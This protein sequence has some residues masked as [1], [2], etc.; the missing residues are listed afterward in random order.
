MITTLIIYGI[1][2]ILLCWL[3]RPRRGYRDFIVA[4]KSSGWFMTAFGLFTL[5][6]G[7][8]L[9]AGASFGY[10][11]GWYGAA[12]FIGYGISF[13]LLA[14][15]SQT[16]LRDAS[17][18]MVSYVDYATAKYGRISGFIVFFA[19]VVA[20]FALLVLQLSAGGTVISTFTSMPYLAA[21]VFC[22]AI[23]GVYL[24]VGGFRAVMITDAVQGFVMFFL[25][26]LIAFIAVSYRGEG[27]AAPAFAS[28]GFD[29]FW[30]V[31]LSGIVIGLASADVW[32]RLLAARSSTSA[33]LGF[34]AGGILLAL[35]GALIV[36]L[37]ILTH[38]YG[39]ATSADDAFLAALRTSLPTPILY[40]AVFA[41]VA[42]I[43]STA[44][45]EIFL[46][47]SLLERQFHQPS[48]TSGKQAKANDSQFRRTYL[49]AI[50]ALAV[51]AAWWGSDLALFFNWLFVGYMAFAPTVAVSMFINPGPRGFMVSLI[52]TCVL[53][54]LLFSVGFLTLE[55]SYFLIIP[56]L[57][58]VPLFAL[59]SH[60]AAKQ[61]TTRKF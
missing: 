7:G 47:S 49:Y 41:S 17:K 48:R 46:V 16:V 15:L 44:D 52:T 20:F 31:I 57:V 32:Q 38:Q 54:G 1:L 45:T 37:G 39:L 9:V 13:I 18:D 28:P 61:M 26:A 8:E 24:A 12:L 5:I 6:G 29:A 19:H 60:R 36:Y 51:I 59:S 25:I 40:A 11:Y 35:Y 53:F 56:A 4:E 14:V 30:G 3:Y 42:A 10:T 33:R 34:I 22:A 58:I 27:L 23:V 21:V 50:V 55:N 43:L 2:I